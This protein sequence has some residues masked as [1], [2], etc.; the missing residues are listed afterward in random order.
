MATVVEAP[1]VVKTTE[2]VV[3]NNKATSIDGK[4]ILDGIDYFMLHGDVI[5]ALLYAA[6]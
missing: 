2:T 4:Y 6:F 1:A 3:D 5:I